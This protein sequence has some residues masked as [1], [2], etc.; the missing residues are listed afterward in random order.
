MHHEWK[1]KG[2]ISNSNWKFN[3]LFLSSWKWRWGTRNRT[4]RLR[5]FFKMGVIKNSAIFTGKPLCWSLF[6]IKLQGWRLQYR[7]FP[8]D[9]TRSLRI[10]FFIEHHG[11]G[12]AKDYLWIVGV[13]EKWATQKNE[14]MRML[15]LGFCR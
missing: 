1:L 8:L 2:D 14:G 6:L 13:G 4:S 10:T 7:C 11:W 3:N 15:G 5:M 12:L 9:I